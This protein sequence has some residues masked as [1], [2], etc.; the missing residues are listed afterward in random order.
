MHQAVTRDLKQYMRAR[1]GR[2]IPVG[3]SAADVSDILT[4]NIAY[5]SCYINDSSDLSRSDFFGLNSYSWCGNATFDSANY[6][7]LT[8]AFQN[9]PIPAIFSEYGCNVP[10]PRYFTEDQAIYG[11]QMTMFSGGLVYQWT[12]EGNDFGLIQVNADGSVQL[13]GD[14]VRLQTQF[15]ML[16]LTILQTVNATAV[17]LPV[18]I[19]APGLISSSAWSS[20]FDLPAQPAGVAALISTGVKGRTASIVSVTATVVRN[21]VSNTAGAVIT[22]LAIHSVGGVNVPTGVSGAGSVSATASATG[23]IMASTTGTA[24]STS[25][26]ASASAT[27]TGAAS[28]A[29]VEVLAG[30]AAAGIAVLMQQF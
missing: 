7:R 13:Q 22:G 15:N 2:T 1:G 5:V 28:R 12:Q 23:S 26:A 18:P 14:F 29:E 17:N 10:S 6:G 24:V 3:Y 8:S 25:A 20:S 11:P 19:C 16:N 4:S 27:K 9:S 30:A 21:V